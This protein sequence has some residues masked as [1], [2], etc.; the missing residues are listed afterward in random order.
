M[1]AFDQKF[2]SLRG[3]IVNYFAQDVSHLVKLVEHLKYLWTSNFSSVKAEETG[4]FVIQCLQCLGSIHDISLLQ[5]C[6]VVVDEPNLKRLFYELVRRR[7]SILDSQMLNG[8]SHTSSWKI[9]KGQVISA[10]FSKITILLHPHAMVTLRILEDLKKKLTEYGGLPVH[11]V[12]YLGSHTL[13]GRKEGLVLYYVL[14]KS[15]SAQFVVY[16]YST[17]LAE[18]ADTPDF[19]RE[20]A[21]D[22]CAVFTPPQ[23]DH[24]DRF[25]AELSELKDRLLETAVMAGGSSC[26]LSL[27]DIDRLF[28]Q[29]AVIVKNASHMF[30][31]AKLH[32]DRDCK[33]PEPDTFQ[34][35]GYY[36]GLFEDIH[37]TSSSSFD[38]LSQEQ[39]VQAT[40]HGDPPELEEHNEIPSNVSSDEQKEVQSFST[41]SEAAV[42]S[43]KDDK[44]SPKKQSE[45]THFNSYREIPQLLLDDIVSS[46]KESKLICRKCY[47]RR[48]G[49]Y[50]VKPENLAT[51]KCP[52]CKGNETV[53]FIRASEH[54]DSPSQSIAV[55]P[56]PKLDPD[57][58]PYT[59][60]PKSE[61]DDC[62]LKSASPQNPEYAHSIEELVIWNVEEHYGCTFSQFIET[63]WG[64]AQ[65]IVDISEAHFAES[66]PTAS[67]LPNAPTLYDPTQIRYPKIDNIPKKLLDSIVA[68]YKQHRYVCQPCYYEKSLMSPFVQHPDSKT[69]ICKAC[70][71]PGKAVLVIPSSDMCIKVADWIPIPPRPAHRDPQPYEYCGKMD[72]NRCYKFLYKEMWFAHT[73]EELVIWT[74]ERDTDKPFSVFV[75]DYPKKSLK[76][77]IATKKKKS[78]SIV[79]RLSKG[80]SGKYKPDLVRF[81]RMRE[82]PS[83][84]LSAVVDC[85]KEHKIVCKGCFYVNKELF[86]SEGTKCRHC[87]KLFE[88]LHVIPSCSLCESYFGD[89]VA[90][91]PYPRGGPSNKVFEYCQ[92]KDH[93]RCFKVY[94]NQGF[95]YTHSVE[96]AVIWTVEREL[97]LP[98]DKCIPKIGK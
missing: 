43:L 32:V 94:Y 58:L 4:N 59:R 26:V 83:D 69:R 85:Y 49:L 1:H 88:P 74:V 67:R 18:L 27:D 61:H 65:D 28:A 76:D 14:P 45:G 35:E 29:S 66:H 54:S 22:D 16:C 11:S 96:E 10:L 68:C 24:A 86:E 57:K 21:I 39:V 63:F 84:L 47:F 77:L 30:P 38:E 70:Q 20:V 12:Q 34:S 72:H 81:V 7:E 53:H 25:V 48:H 71:M 91:P 73:V 19:V 78:S 2:A 6:V 17:L 60:C 5:Q 90:I 8:E 56:T 79:P 3:R 33:T 92:K 15:L 13:V 41:V 87:K 23:Q 31:S 52:K 37:N 93:F 62:Q 44:E 75:T 9:F 95:W 46:F 82:I 89:H 50:I 36:S 55:L 64:R 51:W 98:F 42:E 97:D 80:S 40:L